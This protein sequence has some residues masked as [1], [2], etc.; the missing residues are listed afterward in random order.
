MIFNIIFAKN[1]NYDVILDQCRNIA[2][3][4]NAI[5][6]YQLKDTIDLWAE[7]LCTILT[8]LM[9]ISAFHNLLAP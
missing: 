9:V 2:N 3:E 8:G 5:I 6:I 4:K 1:N 7:K